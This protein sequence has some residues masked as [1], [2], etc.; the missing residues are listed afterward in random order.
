MFVKY[1]NVFD[2]DDGYVSD[3]QTGGIGRVRFLHI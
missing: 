2:N 3:S 1:V